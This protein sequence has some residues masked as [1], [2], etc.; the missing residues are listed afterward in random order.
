MADVPIDQFNGAHIQLASFVSALPY[1]STK[2]YEDYL[3]RLNQVPRVFDQLIDL[4]KQGE[5]DGLM[6]PRFLLEKVV[7]QCESIAEPAGEASAFGQPPEMPLY[8]PESSRRSS[9]ITVS[10]TSPPNGSSS[11]VTVE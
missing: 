2:H 1:D 10:F 5:K 3:A 8:T 11:N 9:W 6:P 7:K 4:L